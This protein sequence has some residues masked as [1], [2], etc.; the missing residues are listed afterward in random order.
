MAHELRA[1]MVL[2]ERY[3]IENKIGEG[4]MGQVYRATQVNLRREVALKLLDSTLLDFDVG[5]RRFLREA[6][7]AAALRHPNAVEIY[8]VGTDG[9]HVFIAMELLDGAV[10]RDYMEDHGPIPLAE[11]LE[12]TLQIAEL[13]VAAHGLPLV[14]RDLKP[15]NVFVQR[16]QADEL[17]VR[18][19]DFG[20]A[21]I[22]G[23]DETGRMTREGLVVGTPAYLSPEQAQ[24]NH[25]GPASDIYSLGCVL[26]EML[27]G[28]C[29]FSGS[30][31]NVLT[32][33]V[34]VAPISLRER[35]PDAG[36]PSDLDDLVMRMLSKRPDDRPTAD[37][38]LQELHTVQGTMAGQRH[39]GRDDRLLQ[40]RRNRM[41]SVPA[42]NPPTIDRQAVERGAVGVERLE[43]GTFGSFSEDLWLGLA[44][45]GLTPVPLEVGQD[46]AA[47]GCHVALVV[48]ED[49]AHLSALTSTGIPVVAVNTASQ[50]E[51]LAELVRRGVSE[52]VSPPLEADVLTRKIRRAVERH[53]RQM[54]RK[55]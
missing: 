45:N 24:G 46:P 22:E 30:Q 52:V 1:G 36:F 50:V 39:R 7:V 6:R 8:D 53:R 10:L 19:V 31:M 18:V 33:H 32:Q 5:R 37:A 4:G 21:F 26:Y 23:S 48:V 17:R 55:Q 9:P 38:M 49:L 2:A 40:T 28:Q 42:Q 3:V 29:V 35:A 15:E 43:V 25:V 47:A 13:L 14:H 51:L 54:K 20:L 34:Y 16:D 27:T 41:I 44:S 12:L 11:A